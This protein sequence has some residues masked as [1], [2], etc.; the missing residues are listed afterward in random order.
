M[1]KK[2]KLFTNLRDALPR[3]KRL[4]ELGGRAS[5]ASGSTVVN[6]SG[7]GSAS[8]GVAHSHNN[9]AQLDEIGTDTDDYLYLS[10]L[11]EVIDPE[12]GE[13]DVREVA[14]KVKA[15]EADHAHSAYD[16]DEDSPARKQ[17]LSRVAD[18]VAAGHITFQQG[19]TALLTAYLKGGAHFGD[20]VAGY[21][22]GTVDADGNGEL[23]SLTIR[24]Y[25]K[26]FELI[27]NRLNA[28]EGTTSFADVGTIETTE[29]GENGT[30]VLTMRKR[31]DGDFTAFQVGD[32]VYGYVNNLQSKNAEY[33]K[34]W[35]W[36]QEVDRVANTLTVVPYPDADVPAG[37]NFPLE[38]E[39]IITRWGNCL[40]ADFNT[41]AVYPEVIAKRGDTYVNTR[42]SSFFISC[43]EGNLVELMG[44]FQPKLT[45]ANYGTVLGK[46]PDGLLDP[47]TEQLIN[48]DQPYLFA[49]GIVVQDII[50]IDYQGN[51]TRTANYRGLWDATTA[52]SDTGYYR[53][54][55][56]AYDT[57]TYNGAL[58][59]CLTGHASTTAPNE[60]NGEWL[61]M[62][63]ALDDGKELRIW[64]LNPSATI[65]NVRNTGVSP[66]TL[67]C[68]VTL[69][70][71]NQ[72]TKQ[73]TSNYDL[74]EE[75]AKLYF[76]VDGE[77]FQEFIIGDTEPI[78]LEDG[79]GVIETEDSVDGSS[80]ITIGGND[81][82]TDTIG[83]RIIFQ[84]RDKDTDEVLATTHV[85]VVKDGS[86]GDY[87]SYV[88]KQQADQ[89]DAPTGTDKIPAGW[90][91]TLDATGR[92]WMSKATIDGV[93][94]KA[95][96]N[97]DGVTWSTPVQCTAEDGAKGNYMDFMYRV[98]PD[99]QSPA[100][101]KTARKPDKWDDAPSYILNGQALWMITAEIDADDKLVGEWSTPTRISGEKGA[102]GDKG[103][104]GEPGPEGPQGLP[105][106]EGLMVYPAGAFESSKTYTATDETAP[107][108]LYN[109]KYYVLRRSTTYT[110]SS[111]PSTTN[112]PAKEVAATTAS[113]SRWILMDKFNA[114]FA[115]VVMADFAKLASAVIYGD[116]MISQQG[117]RN[118][119]T[120]TDYQYFKDGS[121]TP[122][123]ALNF[124]T[125]EMRLKLGV[126][127]NYAK[128]AS[129]IFYGD[130]MISQQGR[131][132]NSDGSVTFDSDAYT[133]FSDG[134]FDPNVAIN[135]RTGEIRSRGVFRGVVSRQPFI[136]TPE[137]IDTYAPKRSKIPAQLDGK[138]NWRTLR[139]DLTGLRIIF[140]GNFG[141]PIPSIW[142]PAIMSH[143]DTGVYTKAEIEE[144]REYIGNILFAQ[145][146]S[147][148]Q[149]TFQG[150]KYGTM[151]LPIGGVAQFTCQMVRGDNIGDTPDLNEYIHWEHLPSF[152]ANAK[153]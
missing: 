75:G 97:K 45:A 46:L 129:A 7:N 52:A 135:F 69:S 141:T 138:V 101:N 147:Q 143:S 79:T 112:T 120:S 56:G 93:T 62:T 31:W 136:I 122:N 126:M 153:S 91:D 80:Y 124:K 140:R 65:V 54:T 145:N 23:E 61:K 64:L 82:A 94:D 59:Q 99:N 128:L 119:A 113:T 30:Q 87:T 8:G 148:T 83:D 3:S 21:A 63:A 92:W 111:E 76:S 9:K 117:E 144:A 22:G 2:F 26:V 38:P 47:A 44:V 81:I 116:W 105:G 104:T 78:D 77:A 100:V 73:F 19:L 43:D 130:W 37:V 121:F 74:N 55:A 114:I 49:R 27:Y 95:K 13:V 127:A 68:A 72:P 84:L 109:E 33:Y 98:M 66:D 39:M 103:D 150:N 18:D 115:D 12:T 70:S 146:E 67:T 133:H 89:P 1:E 71:S 32:I 110:G 14:N 16:L 40:G 35:A 15:G 151:N 17:F 137:N 132:T 60:T 142:L 48:K 152:A 42:Q 20:F 11:R 58:W 125:G 139:L 5:G 29:E 24:S 134:T 107:V 88:F 85:T 41:H 34:C 90:S 131:L 96:P 57:V 53:S 36:I 10:R 118:G 149:I 102:K 108:V 25:L 123:F 28:L 6:V 50:R 106:R 86:A 4:R 51:V